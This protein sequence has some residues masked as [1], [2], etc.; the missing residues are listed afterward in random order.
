METRPVAQL[1]DV[2]VSS[3]REV[4][5]DVDLLTLLEQLSARCEP[6]KPAPPVI[7]AFLDT[8]QA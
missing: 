6:M 5:E 2:A 8:A 3:G 4:V 1:L 7:S